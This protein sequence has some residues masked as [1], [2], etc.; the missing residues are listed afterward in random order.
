VK[1][2]AIIALLV[3][4]ACART[5]PQTSSAPPNILLITIDTLRADRLGRGLTPSIDAVAARGTRFTNAR[6]TVPLTL[7]SH[8]SIMTGEW[9]PENGVRMNGTGGLAAEHPTIARVLKDGGYRTGAFVGAYVLDRRFGLADGFDV[10]DDHV[11]R[12]PSGAAVLEAQRRGDAVVNAALGWLPSTDPRPFFVWI[13]LYDPHAPYDPPAQYLA[14]AKNVPYDGEVAFADAQV[15]RVLEWLTSSGQAGRTVI[16]IAGDHGEGLGD[17]GEMTHGMLAYDATLRVPLVVAR[18]GMPAATVD[19]AVSLVDLAGTLVEL[20]QRPRPAT[21]HARSLLRAPNGP[22]EIYA[23]T[24]YPRQAGWH[25]L[26]VLVADRWK[27]IASSEPELY[28][29][30][31]DPRETRNVAS[32]RAASVAGMRTRLQ[33]MESKVAAASSTAAPVAP[34]VAE[35]LRALGYVSG[36]AATG[37]ADDRAP[38]PARHIAAWN[39]YERELLRL[40]S[41]DARRALPALTGLARAFPDSPLFQSTYARAL[42][43]T[44]RVSEALD[45]YKRL[46]ARW[47]RDAGLYHDLAVAAAAAGLPKEAARAEQAALALEPSNA[48]AANGLGLLHVESGRTTEATAAFEQAVKLDPSN[49]T[50]WTNLGNARR[51]EGNAAAAEQAYRKALDLDPRYADAANG[52]GVLLV[53]AHRA[54]E[55]IPFFERALAGSPRFAEARLNLGIAYQESGNSEK[56]AEQYRQVL[57]LAPPGSR[58]YQA[59]TALLK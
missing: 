19:E 16:A 52:I 55:A 1:Q 17:H 12:D 18:P 34:D 15:G 6:A 56:A 50:F 4:V 27:L 57:E 9:P 28:D 5:P 7:P 11:D 14:R 26:R 45:A 58:E 22:R 25:S 51:A 13:H 30:R 40:T 42:K 53:Q 29:L 36:S 20:A 46:V 23:E 54:G 43:D 37:M 35:R 47:P 21:M 59:A 33:E 41:G 24:E 39:A 2:S 32:E 3:T 8:T 44:G 38:N 48:A 49:A 10:Y 31:D